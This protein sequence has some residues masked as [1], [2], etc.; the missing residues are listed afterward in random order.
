M[1][2]DPGKAAGDKYGHL[3]LGYIAASDW[4]APMPAGMIYWV[5]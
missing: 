1:A 3:Q 5:G 4:D 2:H